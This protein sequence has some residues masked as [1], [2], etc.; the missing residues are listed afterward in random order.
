M[1]N[2]ICPS[3]SCFI[4]VSGPK[5]SRVVRAGFYYRRIARRKVQRFR[6]LNCGLFFS[7]QTHDP[8]Y[9]QKRPDL[10]VKV[11]DL[12]CSQ[13]SQRRCAKL[14]GVSRRTVVNKFRFM[15][16][17]AA[18]ANEERRQRLAQ[19]PVEAAQF[20]DLITSIHSK[21]K[22]VSVSIAVAAKS[23]EILGVHVS[24]IPA[25]HPLI[26]VSLE[27]YGPRKDERPQGLRRLFLGLRRAT[28]PACR[29]YSDCDPEYPSHVAR[30]FPEARYLR[31]QARKAR[32]AGFGELK[33]IG[34]DPLFSLNHT[35]AMLR[36]N[37][38]RLARRTWCTSK[39][40]LGLLLHLELYAHY[41]NTELISENAG[42]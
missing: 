1:H 32:T 9:Y 10:N 39:T 25:R 33:R 34:F 13:V 24:E 22:P 27:K 40:K 18:I 14:L 3:V 19:T 38:N 8:L 42:L 30:H 20:D 26:E 37:L 23:R 2:P 11:R 36:A 35:C 4:P 12:L 5:I 29:L 41:H 17:L 21:C 15:A 16:R 6:C 7:T 31:F 28:T